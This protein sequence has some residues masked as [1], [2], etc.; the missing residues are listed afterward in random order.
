MQNG[1][2]KMGAVCIL[3]DPD[4]IQRPK[5]F[6]YRFQ[7]MTGERGRFRSPLTLGTYVANANLQLI[8]RRSFTIC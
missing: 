2:P 6:D 5:T 8:L 3:T 7:E 1:V 4:P